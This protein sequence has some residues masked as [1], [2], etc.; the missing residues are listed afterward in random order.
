MD[1]QKF[2]YNQDYN[3]N[4]GNN[5]GP[6]FNP[7]N[8]FYNKRSRNMEVAA[9]VLSIIAIASCSCIYVSIICGSLAMIF[10]LLSKGGATSMSSMAMTSF[11]IAFAAVVIT[12]IIYIGSFAAMLQEYGSIEGILK[13]YQ[14]LTGIDYNELLKQMNTAK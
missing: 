12:L 10:A 1:P 9:L 7:N 3:Y 4:F 2:D 14:N 11:W 6:G 8:N 5:Y 13:E